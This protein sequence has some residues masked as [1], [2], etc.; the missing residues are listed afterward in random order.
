MT[1]AVRKGQTWQW[2]GCSC[3]VTR[4][5]KS[6]N[7]ADLR[8]TDPILGTWTKRQKLPLPDDAVFMTPRHKPKVVS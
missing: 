7:W 5:G 1:A 3:L 2:M 4:V 8:V 6:G